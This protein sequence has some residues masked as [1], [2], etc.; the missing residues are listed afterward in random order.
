MIIWYFFFHWFCSEKCF[1]VLF[2][3]KWKGQNLKSYVLPYLAQAA[4]FTLFFSRFHFFFFSLIMVL[5]SRPPK[6]KHVFGLT[7]AFKVTASH[8]QI[9][10]ASHLIKNA[11]ACAFS[12]LQKCYRFSKSTNTN[13]WERSCPYLA[14]KE[15]PIWESTV[16]G[17]VCW[18]I[19]PF[20]LDFCLA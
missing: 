5:V 10:S 12:H 20:K 14:L 2:P 15:K 13:F 19:F 17:S 6:T 11:D 8:D 4:Y 1:R 18:E 3:K 16:L 7:T 9:S